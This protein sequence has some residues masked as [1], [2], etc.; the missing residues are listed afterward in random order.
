MIVIIKT[1]FI[2]RE[3]TLCRDELLFTYI[4]V[5]FGEN[6]NTLNVSSFDLC[7]NQFSNILKAYNCGVF[8]HLLQK[9]F[10]YFLQK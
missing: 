3:N 6:D 7:L 9:F 5:P 1:I 2:C 10:S 4:T 8:S